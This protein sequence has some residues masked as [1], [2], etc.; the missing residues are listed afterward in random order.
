MKK[1][2]ILYGP[3]VGLN[4]KKA[5]GG[6]SG[7]YTRNMQVYLDEFVYDDIQIIPLFHSIDGQFNLSI[8]TLP[9][10][11]LYDFCT[12]FYNLLKI[13]PDGI[14]CLAQY[15]RAFPREFM[16]VFLAFIFRIP[17]LYEV[18]AGAFMDAYE[19]G[20]KLYKRGI[21]FIIKHSKIILVEGKVYIHYIQE[22][23][24]KNSYYF[25]NI[26]K[27]SEVKNNINEKLQ[28]DSISIL[29]VGYCYRGKGV[30]ELVNF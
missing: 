11:L 2:I 6:G 19:S 26:V 24:N 1:K 22:K 12:I 4:L 5:Y 8:F 3:P 23:F 13:K 9:F 29:F 30:F 16:L 14:H 25:P 20:G 15:R 21:D 27:D 17:V 10:R 28:K 18:K 7:G